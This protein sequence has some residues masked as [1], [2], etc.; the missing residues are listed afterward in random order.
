MAV[1]LGLQGK[2]AL[3]TGAAVGIGR[4]IARWLAAAGCDVVRAD[5][6]ATM[7]AEACEEVANAGTKVVATEAD[8]RDPEEV[9]ALVG[10]VVDALGGLDVAVNNVGSLAG[11]TPAAF[12]DLDDD[13][14]RDVVEQNLFVTMWSCHAEAR[15]ML[16]AGTGGV[17]VNV[18]SGETTRPSLRMAHYGAAKAA[19]NHLTETLAVELAPHGIRVLA[20][21]P[22]TT[23]TPVV[24]AA[25]SDDQVAA[26]VDAHPLGRLG[27][28]DD[29]GRLVVALASDLGR[30]V[31]GQVVFGDNGAHLARNRPL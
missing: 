2:R 8:L 31:T 25:L 29:L 27:E 13:A 10:R 1:D 7:L 6:D 11:R 22:G 24:A 12:V 14:L 26:L 15:V 17:I 18:T 3:V 9:R 28:P 23:L 21:A 20:V 19:V 30:S 16:A 4:G 5:K